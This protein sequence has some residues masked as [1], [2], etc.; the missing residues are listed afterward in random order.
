MATETQTSQEMESDGTN[1][2][3]ELGITIPGVFGDYSSLSIKAG[4]TIPLR[5]EDLGKV[6]DLWQHWGDRVLTLATAT[7]D[8][9]LDAQGK[10]TKFGTEE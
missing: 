9:I 4:V 1:S 2:T 7:V 5:Q 3:F 10:S 8:K 6:E